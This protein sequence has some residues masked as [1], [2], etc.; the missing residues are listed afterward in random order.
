MTSEITY[1]NRMLLETYGKG[2]QV[3][4]PISG[5]IGKDIAV[6]LPTYRVVWSTDL[7]ETRY[8][9]FH[10]F[11]ESG[12][13]FLKE[14]HCVE[15]VK[16]YDE[17]VYRDKYILECLLPVDNSNP[18]LAK[19]GVKYSY[20]PIWVFGNA[21][22]HPQPRW[23][24]IPTIVESHLLG[25]KPQTIVTP[26]EIIDREERKMAKQKELDREFLRNEEPDIPFQL[27]HG[28]AVVVPDKDKFKGES[29][30]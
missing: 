12:A 6:D 16:K 17:P 11:S 13:I 28:L 8:G 30:G 22:S 24:K 18:Y 19:A 27:K 5:I 7:E 26:Q 3:R 10:T 21:G 14:E 25:G 29:N 1:I 4:S 2:V 23:D 20:E 15:R 9:E